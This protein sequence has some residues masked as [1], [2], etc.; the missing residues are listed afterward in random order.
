MQSN[1]GRTRTSSNLILRLD[2]IDQIV[3]VCFLVDF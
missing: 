3:A 2:S 1:Q